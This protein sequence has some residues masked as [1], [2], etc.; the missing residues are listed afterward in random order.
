MMKKARLYL[1]AGFL[2]TT[3]L[4]TGCSEE[5]NTP[6]S[7]YERLGGIDAI[8]LVVDRFIGNVVGNNEING[9]FAGLVDG[10]A[11]DVPRQLNLRNHLVDQVCQASGGPCIYKGKSMQAAHAGMNITQDQFNSLVGNLAEALTFYE[12]PQA[13]Q[14]ELLGVLGGLAPEIVGQ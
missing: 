7:L 1:S 6:P 12:V 8:E 5:T 14:D 3:L 10:D 2:A 4:F 11:D 13:E 9:F